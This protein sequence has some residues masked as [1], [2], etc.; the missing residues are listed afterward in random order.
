MTPEALRR[1]DTVIRVGLRLARTARSG[2]VL[3]ARIAEAID[4]DWLPRPWGEEI[5]TELKAARAT[6]AEP[7]AM[8]QIERVLR[9][10]WDAPPKEVLDELDAEPVASTPG[11]Q[12]HRGVLEGEPVAVKVLRPGLAATVR[13]DL[14]LLEGLLAPLGAAFPALDPGAVLEEFRERVLEELDL[15]HE[16]SV[17]RR[18]HR[19]LRQHPF[20]SVPAP[21]MR[22][23]EE[24]VLVSEWVE[25]VPLWRAPDPDQAAA[26]LVLFG[27]GAARWGAIHAD[28]VPDDVLILPDGGLAI[29]DLGAT[30]EVEPERVA[31]SAR[32]F[33]ALLADDVEAFSGALEQLGWLP[34]SHGESALRL[35]C[36]VLGPLGPLGGGG[37]VRLDGDAV[38]AARDRLFER[39][40]AVSQLV[41]AGKLMPEDLWPARGLGQ[42][43]AT[44]ARAGATGD[45][46]ELSRNALDEGWNRAGP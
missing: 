15:E 43:F 32:S 6:A 25:G 38:M 13:G 2:R 26:R 34:R 1:I 11:S 12:V 30:R 20:L 36:E 21:V 41:L 4:L 5:V 18:F 8:E 24:G 27:L 42:L 46:L 37:P 3:L 9:A 23:A 7:I 35:V 16:A 31:L 39:P 33:E 22:L 10:A 44:I 28:L 14:A 17:Q 45:W 19:A 40:D 29:L